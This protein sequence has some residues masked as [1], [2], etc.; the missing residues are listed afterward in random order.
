MKSLL[1]IVLIATC[2]VAPGA[3]VEL[4][5]GRHYEGTVL[6]QDNQR[7]LV[8]ISGMRVQLPRSMIA[9]MDPA[10]GAIAAPEG[11]TVLTPRPIQDET[12]SRP[13]GNQPPNEPAPVN[14]S[15]IERE[16]PRTPPAARMPLPDDPD[17]LQALINAVEL[18][19][20][21]Y[22]E[23]RTAAINTLSSGGDAGL[24]SLVVYGLYNAHP[25]VRMTSANLL[26]S[27]GGRR[28]LKSLIEAFFASAAP[29]I[30]PY[31]RQ[32]VEA[33]DHQI[34]ALTGQSF[35]FY[36]ARSARGPEIAARMIAWWRQNY[37][38][39]PPQL[40]EPAIALTDPHYAQDISDLRKLT[41]EQR[42]FGG[43]SYPPDLV[44]PPQPPTPAEQDFLKTIP[45]VPRSAVYHRDVMT[46]GTYVP[47][48]LPS[49]ARDEPGRTRN[50]IYAERMWGQRP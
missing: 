16:E 2:A 43:T 3:T 37:D 20:S 6:A 39:M 41:L 26:G 7:Y 34:S 29:T 8:D 10:D 11:V 27:L 38:Q 45:N 49:P 13:P 18:L 14:V 36:P 17:Q 33:L 50:E 35:Y 23:A 21:Q 30:P 5:D 1:P 22:P 12:V 32:F 31:Q 25:D 48:Q 4:I 19:D 24:A 44:G 40:G 47:E 9:S 46:N 15:V 42:A 28:V